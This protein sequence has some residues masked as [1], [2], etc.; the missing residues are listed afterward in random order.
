MVGDKI[1]GV[2]EEA[3]EV[4][5]PGVWLIWNPCR[6]AHGF[7]RRRRAA[8]ALAMAAGESLIPSEV[9]V[10]AKIGGVGK[11]AKEVREPGVR[12]IWNPWREAHGFGRR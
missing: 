2:G 6:E 8:Q 3:R 12:W 7:D 4:R 5:E 9:M 10:G 11:E 1:G